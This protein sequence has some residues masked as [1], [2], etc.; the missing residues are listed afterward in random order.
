MKYRAKNG[1]EITEEALKEIYSLHNFTTFNERD[2]N[3]WKEERIEQG[4]ITPM[5]EQE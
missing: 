1:L 5:E 2:Y 3:A 4:V